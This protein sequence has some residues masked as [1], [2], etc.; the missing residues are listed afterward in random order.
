MWLK[1]FHLP[2]VGKE[3]AWG[4]SQGELRGSKPETWHLEPPT[5]L[6]QTQGQILLL[7]LT[8]QPAFSCS[9]STGE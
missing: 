8:S 5:L 2:C 3:R 1:S 9:V 4:R 6:F 7:P